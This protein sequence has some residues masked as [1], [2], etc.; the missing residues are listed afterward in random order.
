MARSY[1]QINPLGIMTAMVTGAAAMMGGCNAAAWT[2]PGIGENSSRYSRQ[3][4]KNGGLPPGN[5]QTYATI[6][7]DGKPIGGPGVKGV[8]KSTGANN[9]AIRIEN[10]IKR[11]TQD[12]QKPIVVDRKGARQY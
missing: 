12:L 8:D 6:G 3:N 1:R 4:I 11:S 9:A 10:D 5:I 7:G 2:G